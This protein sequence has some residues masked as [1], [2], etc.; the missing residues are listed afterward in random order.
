MRR[1]K[2]AIRS[3][4]WGS[5]VMVILMGELDADGVAV[6][7][8]KLGKLQQ[9]NSVLVDLWDVSALDPG[10]VRVLAA[11]KQRAEASGWGLEIVCDPNGPCAAAIKAAGSPEGLTVHP[12]R[13]EA[14]AALQGQP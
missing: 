11:A 10:A 5:L 6:L 13:N 14:R 9:G 7:S 2:F 1:M 8:S 4:Y 3:H 12:T